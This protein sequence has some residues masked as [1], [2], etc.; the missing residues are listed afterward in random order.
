MFEDLPAN[1]HLAF[2]Y[3]ISFE[4]AVE[5]AFFESGFKF[6]FVGWSLNGYPTYLKMKEPIAVALLESK[7]QVALEPHVGERSVMLVGLDNIYFSKLNNGFLKQQEMVA[8]ITSTCSW[9][10][11]CL[12]WPW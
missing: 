9:E 2:D 10:S 4:H 1:S 12:S 5:L 7:I 3:A 6:N 8:I 11:F